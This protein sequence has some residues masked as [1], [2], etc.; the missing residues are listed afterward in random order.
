MTGPAH[1]TSGVCAIC[2][3]CDDRSRKRRCSVVAE[4][5]FVNEEALA[6]AAQLV[7]DRLGTCGSG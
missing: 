3:V 7:G 2:C 1:D 4:A 5:L 6:E